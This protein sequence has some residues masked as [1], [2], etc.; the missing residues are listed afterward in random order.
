MI[1]SSAEGEDDLSASN[2]LRMG[3]EEVLRAVNDQTDIV[4]DVSSL[5]RIAYLSL[6]LALLVTM[7]A[8]IW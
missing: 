7:F 3:T 4:L 2:A 8:P 5:P 1:G 6:M